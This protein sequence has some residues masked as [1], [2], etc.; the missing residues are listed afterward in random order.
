MKNNLLTPGRILAPS[1]DILASEGEFRLD[2]RTINLRKLS[3]IKPSGRM[4]EVLFFLD[5]V[6]NSLRN[7][8]DLITRLREL[9]SSE[10]N[11]P[12]V[13]VDCIDDVLF[14][15]RFLPASSL[16]SRPGFQVIKVLLEF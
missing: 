7:S 15:L 4:G 6:P 5:F 9:H 14:G 2:D 13:V 8:S 1:L 10:S 12:N 16:L 3:L 11:F